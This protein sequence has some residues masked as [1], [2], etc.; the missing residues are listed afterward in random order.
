MKSSQ[1]LAG[2]TN[3]VLLLSALV[4]TGVIVKREF[5][6]G[7]TGQGE[8]VTMMPEPPQEV[9]ASLEN[10]DQVIGPPDSPVTLIVFTDYE[11]PYCR[12]LEADIRE[13]TNGTVLENSLRVVVR[14]FPLDRVHP[15]ARRAAAAAICAGE[16]GHFEG[17][18]RAL[19]ARQGQLGGDMAKLYDSLFV[20]DASQIQSFHDCLT[21]DR[22][23]ARLAADHSLAMRVGVNATPTTVIDGH[24]IVGSDGAAVWRERLL[25]ALQNSGG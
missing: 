18:H 3:L 14:H 9:L 6:P 12:Q 11:C 7:A 4:M 1:R 10:D 22:I 16:Q 5:S 21:A 2:V 15:N 13:A 17:F 19:F 8:G 23:A 20:G 24:V 25:Q